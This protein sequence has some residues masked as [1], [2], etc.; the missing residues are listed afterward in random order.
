[1]PPLHHSVLSQ[2]TL[3]P[4]RLDWPAPAWT[5]CAGPDVSILVLVTSCMRHNQTWDKVRAWGHEQNPSGGFL[6]LAGRRLDTEY[7]LSRE[8]NT[9]FVNCSDEY[10]ALPEKLLRGF[11]SVLDAPELAGVTH[12]FKVDDTDITEP[13]AYEELL[14]PGV[15]S[16][17]PFELSVAGMERQLHGVGGDYFCSEAGMVLTD[18]SEPTGNPERFA[19]DAASQATKIPNNSYWKNAT[20]ICQD[21]FAF[22]GGGSGYIMSRRALRGISEP[23]T[24]ALPLRALHE[25]SPPPHR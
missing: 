16:P 17:Y 23:C 2:H 1:M 19:W 25:C 8:N 11:T 22:C 3:T 14:G 7:L 12:I 5:P 9:L 21:T 10:D 20:F 13:S 15:A 6:I 18:C 24:R 4:A